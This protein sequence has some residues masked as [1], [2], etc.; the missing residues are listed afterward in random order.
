MDNVVGYGWV[1]EHDGFHAVVGLV[2]LVVHGVC[3]VGDVVAGVALSSDVYFAVVQVEGVDE[4]LPE[5]EE[6]L[7]DFEFVCSRGC[8]ML[9]AEA[10]ACWLLHPDNIGQ[11]L[12]GPLIF[13][14]FIG[15]V[16]P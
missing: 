7:Y 5:S 1:V 12:P 9:L 6:L 8:A 3:D 15:P 10:R 14:W 11:V 2:S 13:D 16:L 4:V